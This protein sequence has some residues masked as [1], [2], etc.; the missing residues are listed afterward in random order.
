ME[1]NILFWHRRDLRLEDNHGLYKAL[2]SDAKVIPI[3]IFD[4]TILA[5]L[6]PDDQR[7]LFIHQEITRLKSEYQNV[8]SDLMVY[9]GNPVE[10]LPKICEEFFIQK[11][12]VNRDYEPNALKRDAAIFELLKDKNIDFV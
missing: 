8:G 10:L 3:F 1:N 2:K 12:V 6:K 11:V 9:F 5:R 4:T 7:I